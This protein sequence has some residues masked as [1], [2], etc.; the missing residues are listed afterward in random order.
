MPKIKLNKECIDCGAPC[1]V[2]RCVACS[3]ARQRKLTDRH[4][5]PSQKKTLSKF[6]RRYKITLPYWVKTENIPGEYSKKRF[7]E[8]GEQA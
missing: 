3:N 5:N 8:I 6:E 4:F 7:G 1:K 2:K